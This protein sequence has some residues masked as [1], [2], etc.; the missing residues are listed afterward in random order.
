MLRGLS[1]ANLSVFVGRFPG[2]NRRSPFLFGNSHGMERGRAM[3]S[4]RCAARAAVVG[5]MVLLAA[6][7]V[8]AIII[9]TVP[10]GNPGNAADTRYETPGYG[11]VNYEYRIGKYEVTASQYTAFLN[12]LGGV[13]TYSLYNPWMSYGNEGCGITR[14]GGGTVGDP[15]TYSVAADFAN[16]PANNVSFWNACRFANWLS[17]NQPTGAQ[18]PGT[19]ETGAYTL[20]G[21][22]GVDGR[23]IQRN[24][25]ATW[26]VP[27]EDEWYKAAYYKGGSTNAGYWDYPTSSDTAPGQDMNDASGNNANYSTA[28]YT[29]PIDNGKY[30]T[31]VG[32]FQNSPSPYGT[33]DQGGNVWEWDEAVVSVSYRGLRGGAFNY[34]GSIMHASYRGVSYYTNQYSY[35]GGFRVSGVPEPATMGLLALGGLGMLMRRRVAPRTDR[36]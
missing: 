10:V 36:P 1:N 9:D 29:M 27:S 20:N 15:Y 12:A 5:V 22:N 16:R 18:G 32:E 30:T 3:V 17:N 21:Y 34:G 26:A 7:A 14:N 25:G 24:P 6:G 31:L 11:A 23:T 28:P 2:E 33:F 13:D 4:I 8:Q 35:S 19:T